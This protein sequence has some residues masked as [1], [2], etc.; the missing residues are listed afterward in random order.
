MTQ[1]LRVV[2]GQ[3]LGAAL[4]D[5]ERGLDDRR[6]PRVPTGPGGGRHQVQH[7]LPGE[8]VDEPEGRSGGFAWFQQ[9]ERGCGVQR[10]QR[11][12]LA[13]LGDGEHGG[14]VD[15]LADDRGDL[16]CLT[17]RRLHPVQTALH[18]VLDRRRSLHRPHHAHLIPRPPGRQV[19]PQLAEQE[20]IAAG[21]VAQQGRGDAGAVRRQPP[22][23][24]Q[25]LGDLL[26]GETGQV[27]PTDAVEP[28][29]VGDGRDQRRGAVRCGGP[30]RGEHQHRAVRS[31]L[32]DVDQQLQ[33]GTPR[34]VHVLQRQHHRAPR[35]EG[36]DRVDDGVVEDP[37]V[38]RLQD[39]RGGPAADRGTADQPGESLATGRGELEAARQ[40]VLDRFD[41]RLIGRPELRDARAQQHRGPTT[42]E[43]PADLG[44][45]SR[46]PGPRLAAQEDHLPRAA[47][48]RGPAPLHLRQLGMPAD[49]GRA[50]RAGPARGQRRSRP[51]GHPCGR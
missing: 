24:D 14:D 18:A 17:L 11:G 1:R 9:A 23:A 46:L 26:G 2:V 48:D 33:G 51:P 36:P 34:P 20:G 37:A 25:V 3:P 45:Q 40:K 6:D 38:L 47:G 41:E 13:P 49:E 27:Q 30:V 28:V 44:E 35:G 22:L 5:G 39:R 19:P 32:G 10:G 7:R 4:G 50:R 16:H 15:V 8:G 12:V 43:D 29:E 21:L 42:V 31:A